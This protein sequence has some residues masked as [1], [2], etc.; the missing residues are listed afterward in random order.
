MDPRRITRTVHA[1]GV[2]DV[3]LGNSGVGASPRGLKDNAGRTPRKR[4]RETTLNC[5]L[6]TAPTCC[7]K[8]WEHKLDPVESI[9]IHRSRIVRSAY[10]RELRAI[11]NREFIVKLLDRSEHRSS[12][13]YADRLERWLSS[14]KK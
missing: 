1:F 10:I 14:E 4:Q 9:R 2:R 6:K 8:R 5:V 11:E 13:T 7:G 12:R 3:V